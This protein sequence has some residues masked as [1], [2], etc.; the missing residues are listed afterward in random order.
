[1]RR[2]RFK[3]NLSSILTVLA[4]LLSSILLVS[5]LLKLKLYFS[6]DQSTLIQ[7]KQWEVIEKN[8]SCYELKG[9]YQI[10][11]KGMFVPSESKLP[12]PYYLNR[13][14]AEKGVIRLSQAPQ[15]VW[16]SSQ[17]PRLSSLS[18][19]FPIKQLCY[20]LVTVGA[21]LYF[22]FL[23]KFYLELSDETHSRSLNPNHLSQR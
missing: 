12:P 21:T 2:L 20:L 17:D 8:T 23:K 5:F 3:F 15:T 18:K 16:F 9:I 6:L 11:W 14:S 10:N 13:V 19:Q 7:I 4:A 1:M 22:L